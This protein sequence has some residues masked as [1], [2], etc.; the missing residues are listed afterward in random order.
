MKKIL[1]A[2]TAL[3]VILALSACEDQAQIASRNVSKAADNFQVLRRVV[4]YNSIR[5]VYMLSIEGLCSI[6]DE[7]KQLEVTCKIAEGDFKKHF[8]GLSDNVTYFAEQMETVEVSVY[9]HKVIFRP[10]TF[11]PDIKLDFD[12]E[13]LGRATVNK[14]T[15][16]EGIML[17]ERTIG[18]EPAVEPSPAPEGFTQE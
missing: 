17:E 5:D 10:Q 11:L 7:G 1:L 4:F 9:H 13:E 12:A 15:G 6:K 8:L 16:E 3:G 18:V 14:I 2:F